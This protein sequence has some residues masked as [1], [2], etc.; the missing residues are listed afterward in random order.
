MLCA[1]S[2]GVVVLVWNINI[3]DTGPPTATATPSAQLIGVGKLRIRITNK[4]SVQF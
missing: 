2:G 3:A 4:I 1:A